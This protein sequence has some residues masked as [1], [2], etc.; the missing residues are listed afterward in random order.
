M[1][2]EST[3]IEI[4][5]PLANLATALSKAQAMMTGAKKDKHNDFFKSQYSTLS[6]ILDAIRDPFAVNGL[7]VTQ[8]MEVLPTGLQMLCTRLLHNSGEYI[9]SKMLLPTESNPQKMGSL[10][11]YLRKYSLMA[12]AGVA[13]EDD[14][15]NSASGNAEPSSPRISIEQVMEL[16]ELINGN[17]RVRKMVLDNCRQNMAT[18][19]VDRYAGALKWIK[20]ELKKDEA[21][22]G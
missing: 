20:S 11:T 12:I 6:S 5:Q 14:D 8:T 2:N 1:E 13:S 21:I 7:S 16:E 10:I 18:I 19:T 3:A 17:S 22:N 9:D 15:G 4:K